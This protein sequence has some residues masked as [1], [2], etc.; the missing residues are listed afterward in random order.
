M[1]ELKIFK[2][3]NDDKTFNDVD[4]PKDELD[5]FNFLHYYNFELRFKKCNDTM[6]Y[7]CFVI[8]SKYFYINISKDDK[9]KEIYD[10]HIN[11]ISNYRN[12]ITLK[13]YKLYDA[14]SFYGDLK[15]TAKFLEFFLNKHDKYKLR[16]I[17][18]KELLK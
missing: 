18:Y 12:R 16:K 3:N 10:L 5:Y 7:S 17:K 13:D 6:W 14:K 2:H 8:N 4:I 1:R 9:E 11:F 15:E